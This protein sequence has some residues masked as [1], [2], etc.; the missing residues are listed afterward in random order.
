MTVLGTRFVLRNRLIEKTGL[1]I[2]ECGGNGKRPKGRPATVRVPCRVTT[3][4]TSGR[5]RGMPYDEVAVQVIQ[6][7]S[8]MCGI[9]G[10]EQM[11]ART[12]RIS[13]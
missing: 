3:I 5:G 7:H 6:V 12:I 2:L 11:T 9:G 8:S 13:R 10:I 1:G 4:N